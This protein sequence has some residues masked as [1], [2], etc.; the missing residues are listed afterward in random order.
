MPLVDVAGS[1]GTLPPEQ[2]AK[3]VPKPNTGITFGVTVTTKFVVAAHCP[4]VGVN[5]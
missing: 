1:A 2:I 5:V 3:A 4:D